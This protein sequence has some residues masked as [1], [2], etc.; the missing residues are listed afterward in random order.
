MRKPPGSWPSRVIDCRHAREAT[1]HET[2]E[3]LLA[4]QGMI[5]AAAYARSRRPYVKHKFCLL[6]WSRR[7]QPDAFQEI[8]PDDVAMEDASAILTIK[9][10]ITA[11]ASSPSSST[12]IVRAW[13]IGCSF[14]T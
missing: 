6:L 5:A 10:P 8:D 2:D 1:R 3:S 9:E 4:G 7:F 14:S 12:S 11:A 13:T